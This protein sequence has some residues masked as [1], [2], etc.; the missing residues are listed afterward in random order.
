MHVCIHATGRQTTERARKV[1]EVVALAE[2]DAPVLEG[3]DRVWVFVKQLLR[4]ILDACTPLV[5][6][7]PASESPLGTH[8]AS[9]DLMDTDRAVMSAAQAAMPRTA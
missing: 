1:Q 8:R 5:G 6:G 2:M 7:E 4:V 3:D 9:D